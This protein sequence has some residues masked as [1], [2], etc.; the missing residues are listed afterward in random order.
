MTP[1]ALPVVEIAGTPFEMGHALGRHARRAIHAQVRRLPEFRAL[2]P[3]LEEPYLAELEATARRLAPS[4][5]AEIEGLA[6]GAEWAFAEALLWNLK[7]DLR[8]A[9]EP[10]GHGC[11]TLLAREG[12]AGRIVHN[13]DGAPAHRDDGFMVRARPADGLAFTSFAYPGLICGNSFAVNERGLVQTLNNIRAHDGRV[14]LPRQLVARA[15]LDCATL[16]AAL[17]LL[18]SRPRASGYHHGLAQAGDARVLAVE[19]PASGVAVTTVDDRAAHANHLIAPAFVDLA[20]AVTAS[21]ARRQEAAERGF[22]AARAD[23]LDVL[24]DP[25]IH[26]RA[27]GADDSWTLAT[28][29]FRVA[30]DAVALDVFQGE[31]TRSVFSETVRP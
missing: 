25:A 8:A 16:D 31:P 18:A 27:V 10:P 14:G 9:G 23:A 29:R 26:G 5:V 7:G 6:V 2:T 1:S 30:A 12:D 28:A 4:Y 21:S 24:L 11:T 22:V 13:E 20:Q 17:A 15:V 19:A 3:W